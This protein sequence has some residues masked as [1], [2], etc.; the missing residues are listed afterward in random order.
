MTPDTHGTLI[1]GYAAA[2]CVYLAYVLTLWAR[3]RRVRRRL[4][5]RG[6]R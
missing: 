3:I 6:R 4:E 2:T 1:A 5:A